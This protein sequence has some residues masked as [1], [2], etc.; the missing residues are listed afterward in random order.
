MFHHFPF[1]DIQVRSIRHI[2]TL[3]FTNVQLGILPLDLGFWITSFVLLC[4]QAV[5]NTLVAVITYECLLPTRK[6]HFLVGYGLVVPALLLVPLGIYRYWQPP[7]IAIMLTLMG[8]VPNILTLR[9]LEA[10]HGKLPEYCHNNRKMLCLYFSSTLLLVFRDGK[11]V[12]FTRTMFLQKLGHFVSVFLQTSLLLSLLLANDYQ[13]F[14]S[15]SSNLLYWGNLGN[16]L[17]LASLTSLVLDGGASGL[18]LLTSCVTGYALD[19]F[20]ES[21]LTQSTSP[22]DFWGRRWD[23]P[24]QSAL[25]RGCY[26]PLRDS[27]SSAVAAFGTF[28]ISGFIH[29]YVLLTFSYR[30]QHSYQPRYG[31][32]FIFFLWNGVVLILERYWKEWT[33]GYKLPLPQPLQTA[34][35]LMTVLPIGHLF[36]DEYVRASFYDDTSWGFPILVPLGYTKAS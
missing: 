4:G 36:T 28:V 18:G 19:S 17:L 16:A 11:P 15:H 30:G 12:P 9:V 13:V 26:A 21:P 14:P 10:M 29:E 23:R 31:L 20:C 32:Q 8:A 1:S 5:I 2:V 3:P 22:S 7:N 35:V 6:N 24:V 25:R 34:L 33:G 27:Y